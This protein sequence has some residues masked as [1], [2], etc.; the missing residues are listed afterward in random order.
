MYNNPHQ[1]QQGETAGDNTNGGSEP[2]A[3]E[4]NYYAATDPNTTTARDAAIF[5]GIK[6]LLIACALVFS[7]LI[8]YCLF[9][10][11]NTT[12]IKNACGGMWELLLARVILS[13]FVGA[14]LWI[15]HWGVFGFYIP[16]LQDFR[17]VVFFFVYFFAFSVAEIVII[18][19]GVIGNALC[20]ET[21]SNHSFTGTPLL[22]ILGFI[23][24]GI[25]CCLC[26]MMGV[27]II[28]AKCYY[29]RAG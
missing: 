19:R 18:P 17:G 16:F 13:V 9:G 8:L 25:D 26:V 7:G 24:L 12:S 15:D 14:L 20:V 5:T 10:S 3:L 21:L 22:G 27:I 1:Q 29:S 28:F 4:A 23:H 11:G 2:G 6:L